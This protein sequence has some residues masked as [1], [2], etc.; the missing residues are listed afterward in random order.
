MAKSF[1][2]RTSL[3]H[4]TRCRAGHIDTASR[5]EESKVFVRYNGALIGLDVGILELLQMHLYWKVSKD[6]DNGSFGGVF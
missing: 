3:G 1:C 4:D 6:N 5:I 2:P